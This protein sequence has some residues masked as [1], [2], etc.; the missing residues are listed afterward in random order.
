MAVETLDNLRKAV[1]D[2]DVEGAANWATKAVEERTDPIEAVEALTQTIR[3]VGDG[4]ARGELWLPELVGAA[5]AM[6]SAMPIIE[7]EIKRTGK[8][9]ETL[10]TVVLGAVYGDIHD[11]GKN[12]VA[13]LLMA[14][15]YAVHDL[16]I[17]IT[18]EEF[19]EAVR[20]H[21]P[22][23]LAMS[24]LLTMTSYEQMNVITALKN[25]G[26]RDQVKI[27]VGGGAITQ[28]FADGIGADG[29]E[30]SAPLAAKLANRLM[31]IE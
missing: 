26:L 18:A 25:E 5:A 21:K 3:Q 28:E 15:G 23:I 29:Y 30:P 7:E 14:N 27:M 9:R 12:M 24:A 6:K 10:G 20:K 19:V 2:Y 8:K 22:D 13:T 16:G 1:L 17:N 4:F 31:G 11:I